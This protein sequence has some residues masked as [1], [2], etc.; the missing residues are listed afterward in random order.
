MDGSFINVSLV[1]G[2]GNGEPS[3]GVSVADQMVE[4][5]IISHLT[6][7]LLQL[8]LGRPGRDYWLP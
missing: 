1:L 3:Q 2:A 7:V 4:S 6:D 5:R 8:C